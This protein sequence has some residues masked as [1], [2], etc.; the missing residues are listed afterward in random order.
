[1]CMS[2]KN[3]FDKEGLMLFIPTCREADIASPPTMGIALT[4]TI[5]VPTGSSRV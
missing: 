1:M 3:T 5:T 2:E 4:I